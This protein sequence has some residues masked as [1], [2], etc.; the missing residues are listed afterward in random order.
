MEKVDKNGNITVVSGDDDYITLQKEPAED[1]RN[2]EIWF[3]VKPFNST[4]TDDTDAVLQSD[5]NNI[6]F[7]DDGQTAII[8][9]NNQDNRIRPDTYKYDLQI[10]NPITQIKTY[11]IG[12]YKVLDDVTK[13]K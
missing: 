12:K 6:T 13:T 3:T 1:L 11:T 5:N 8:P 2:Y 4:R 10:K 7:I 9:I